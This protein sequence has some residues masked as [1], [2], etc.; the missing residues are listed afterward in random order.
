MPKSRAKKTV[1]YDLIPRINLLL[2]VSA[3]SLG[4]YFFLNL[5]QP[6]FIFPLEEKTFQAE[7]LI[8][9][10]NDAQA[11]PAFSDAIFKN[12]PLFFVPKETEHTREQAFV[13]LGVST[14]TRT[15]ALIR[16][17]RAKNDYYCSEGDMIE[18]LK[19]IRITKDKVTLNAGGSLLEITR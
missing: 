12:K 3:L 4:A 11:M 2:G 14:G 5:T 17:R 18:G 13:L 16:D 8:K 7:A 6:Y 19:I 15:L 1:L 10:T 9:A